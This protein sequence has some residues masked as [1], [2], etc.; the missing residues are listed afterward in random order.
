MKLIEPLA[1][2]IN[3][4]PLGTATLL[5]R[6]TA[7]P[8]TWYQD[9]EATQQRSGAVALDSNGSAVVYVNELVE[10]EVFDQNGVQARNFVAG[11][12]AP[13]VE[14]ISQSFTGT[15]YT[16]G[17]SGASLPT[18]LQAVLDAWK[19]SAGATDFKVLESGSAV[20]LQA[21]AASSSLYFNVQ[22]YGAKGDGV[23]DDTGAIQSATSAAVAAGGGVVFFPP[24]AGY[25]ISDAIALSATNADR[26]SFLGA[27]DRSVLIQTSTAK[28]H[29]VYSAGSASTPRKQYIRDIFLTNSVLQTAAMVS[30][31]GPA[32]LDIDN[33]HFS[34]A[35]GDC[36]RVEAA[37]TN[38]F[39][40]GIRNSLFELNTD[41]GAAV[42][43]LNTGT[44]FRFSMSQCKVTAFSY[45][46]GAPSN[47][48]HALHGSIMGCLFD[49]S[50][51]S[52]GSIV[53]IAQ[54][55]G[56]GVESLNVAACE[57]RGTGAGNSQFAFRDAS[58]NLV[59]ESGNAF[60][61]VDPYFDESTTALVALSTTG[62]HASFNGAPAAAITTDAATVSANFLQS[63]V[64]S[65]RRT[66]NANQLITITPA[67]AL[68]RM[69]TLV[70]FNDSGGTIGINGIV[71]RNSAASNIGANAANLTN[72]SAVMFNFI[73]LPVLVGTVI[74]KSMS[75]IGAETYSLAI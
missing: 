74:H 13:A 52:S 50:G 4:C 66:T 46:G 40:L 65:I 16:D 68:G 36:V 59:N 29:F 20:T 9:F 31:T 63:S 15:S 5:K 22:A 8:A 72:Q 12:A 43:I 67:P 64:V 33:V 35:P 25:N 58:N 19:T 32:C 30:V 51:R 18:T 26:V 70:V 3:G 34:A 69:V 37:G 49:M 44:A 75:L 60:Y 57:F 42:N 21:L 45:A 39:Q 6:G 17:S 48:V 54:L 56:T 55:A 10:V 11:D 23:T 2:G 61:G 41:P 7:T 38:G 24:S 71:V 47:W 1:S 53:A 62:R 73:V 27:G 14:V 28:S